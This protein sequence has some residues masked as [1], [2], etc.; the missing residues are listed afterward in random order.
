MS[1][2]ALVTGLPCTTCPSSDAMVEYLNHFFCFSCRRRTNKKGGRR[3]YSITPSVSEDLICEEEITFQVDMFSR[4]AKTWLYS[5]G[6]TDKLIKLYKLGY[7]PELDRVYIP[8]YRDDVLIGYQ[9]RA[10]TF[11]N[12]PKYLGKGPKMCYLSQGVET[13]EVVLVEDVLSCIRVGEHTS[14]ISLQGTSL[15]DEGLTQV[16]GRFNSVKIWLDSDL[17]GVTGTKKLTNRLCLFIPCSSIGTER[18]PKTYTHK[19]IGE[20]LSASWKM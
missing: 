13:D 17:A 3:S 9:T 2:G 8:N 16:L 10:L 5:V 11:Y 20:I 19:E 6:I 18:D 4:S 15:N 7:I 1:D 12:K 14:A